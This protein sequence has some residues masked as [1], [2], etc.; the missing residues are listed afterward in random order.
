MV[1]GSTVFLFFFLP[2][3]LAGYFLLPSVKYRNNWLFMTSLFF[4]FYGGGY[5]SSHSLIHHHSELHR[6]PLFGNIV[7]K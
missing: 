7:R 3:V 5:F 4:Y 2:V 1:F 6:R